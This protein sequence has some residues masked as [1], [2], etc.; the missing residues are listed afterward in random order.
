[1]KCLIL[2][3]LVFTV[4]AKSSQEEDSK[5]E[6]GL[7][8]DE[9]EVNMACTAGT[10][11][12]VKIAQASAACMEASTEEEFEVVTEIVANRR[13]KCRGRRCKGKG[14]KKCPSV[15]DVKE[16]METEMEGDLCILSQLGWI[17]ADGQAIEDVMAADL[18]TLPMDVSAKLSEDKV[19]ECADKMVTKMAKKHKRCAKMYSSDDMDQLRELGLKVASYKCFEK[20]FAKSCQEFVRQEIYQFYMEKMTQSGLDTTTATS[21]DTTPDFTTTVDTTT[22]TSV[23]T[24][25]DFTT[26][27]DT[28]TVLV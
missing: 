10:P 12:G 27:V 28:T 13:R 5:L 16:K 8:F 17:D 4:A 3:C 1:M 11:L 14:K 24:T 22:A 26:S 20:Q 25:P 9:N 21:V 18:M 19:A 7:Y 15:D 23:D 6:G 2:L